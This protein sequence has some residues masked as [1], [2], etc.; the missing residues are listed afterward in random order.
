MSSPIE[1]DGD[2]LGLG[3]KGLHALRHAVTQPGA[4]P[5][6]ALLDAGYT[7][8]DEIYNCFQK[9]LPGFAGVQDPSELDAAKLGEVLSEF[10]QSLGWGSVVLER[11]GAAGLTIDSPDWAEAEP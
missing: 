10:F 3:R 6:S 5:A 9:W 4:E 11:L 7:A 2:V 1:L 8:G